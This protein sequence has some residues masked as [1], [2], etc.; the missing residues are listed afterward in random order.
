MV[1]PET[2]QRTQNIVAK[3]DLGLIWD[4]KWDSLLL[5]LS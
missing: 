2:L 5:D 3:L 1:P 4:I